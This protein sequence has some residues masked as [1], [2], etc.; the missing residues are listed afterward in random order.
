MAENVTIINHITGAIF[1]PDSFKQ[2][3]DEFWN[4][5]KDDC[6]KK[7]SKSGELIGTILK[8]LTIESFCAHSGISIE[9]FRFL[10]SD[11]DYKEYCEILKTKLN[12]RLMEGGLIGSY[13][14]KLVMFNAERHSPKVYEKREPKQERQ[15][16]NVMVM[17]V[18]NSNQIVE[19]EARH[20]VAKDE[21]TLSG[22]IPDFH[23]M[24]VTAVEINNG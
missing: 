9:T 12:A 4:T 24:D 1:T 13:S 6:I 18:I 11:S 15:A 3:L 5:R 7:F 17:P 10:E 19:F 14:D 20:L 21:N 22:G 2:A 8:P 16:I 23:T